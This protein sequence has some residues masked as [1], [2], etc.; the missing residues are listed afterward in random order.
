MQQGWLPAIG[1]SLFSFPS[2]LHILSFSFPSQC[3][4]HFFYYYFFLFFDK[5]PVPQQAGLGEDEEE[6]KGK[7]T[8]GCEALCLGVLSSAGGLGGAQRRRRAAKPCR[9]RVQGAP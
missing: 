3:K 1:R 7:Q 4:V 2:C 9:W 8:Q 6:E 5:H